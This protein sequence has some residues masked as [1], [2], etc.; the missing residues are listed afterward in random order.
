[1]GALI[2]GKYRNYT[3]IQMD[4]LGVSAEGHLKAMN[5]KTEDSIEPV[6][7]LGTKKA[8]GYT[9]GDEMNEGSIT[10]TAEFMQQVR[11]KLR[12]GKT[13]KDL[14]PIPIA[15][16]YMGDLGILETHT[17]YGVKF[18]SD[19][20]SGESGST[21]ALVVEIPLFIF[22]IDFGGIA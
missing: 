8:V 17:L 9:Q 2:N 10:L 22:D 7:V 3:S 15:I 18:K 12:R 5:Y 14:P 13:I 11:K 4:L 19:G 16:S 21:D 1:M 6:K 20:M